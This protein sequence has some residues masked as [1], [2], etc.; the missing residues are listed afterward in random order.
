MLPEHLQREMP[1][2][3]EVRVKLDIDPQG[4]V[5]RVEVLSKVIVGLEPLIQSA[6]R[7]WRFEPM[8][9]RA[10]AQVTLVFRTEE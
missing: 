2:D 9:D 5:Y 1:Q 3:T 7:R 10:T 6:L 8:A 4:A